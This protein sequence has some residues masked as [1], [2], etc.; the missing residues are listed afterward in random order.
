ML[1]LETVIQATHKCN[2][3]RTKCYIKGT[4]NF[5]GLSTFCTLEQTKS[6]IEPSCIGDHMQGLQTI[7][8][9]VC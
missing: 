1:K 6:L 4:S 9:D 8:L 3:L 2:T 7:G 5:E